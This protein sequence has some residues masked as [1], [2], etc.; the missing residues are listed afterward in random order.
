MRSTPH[1][2][3]SAAELAAAPGT[4]ALLD[5]R[6]FLK[7]GGREAYLDGHLPGAAFVDLDSELCGTPGA[8]G[9]HPLP[10]PARLQAALRAAGVR[11]GQPVVVYDAGGAPPTGAAARAWWT[12]RWAGLPDVRVLDGGYAAW[13][14]AGLPTTTE[15]PSPAPG[16]V[17]VHPGRMSTVD[18]DD[19]RALDVLVDARAPERYRGETEPIDP[20]AGRIPGAVNQPVVET[21]DAGGRLLGAAELRR[22]FEALGVTDRGTVGA[23]CGSGVTAA[24]TV[25]ALT[26]AGFDPVLY[27]GSWS[28]WITDPNRPVEKGEPG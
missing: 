3:V 26:V 12:L 5:V 17:I 1:P 7:G 19:V 9:R 16:D 21:V 20:V 24:A 27:V 10:D 2:L 6:W 14:A 11:E 25:L 18:A 15:V 8:S 28:H 13:A 23:Y 22:R 4:H